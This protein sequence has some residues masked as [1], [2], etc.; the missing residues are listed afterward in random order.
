MRS[1]HRTPILLITA[2]CVLGCTLLAA[3]GRPAL[4]DGQADQELGSFMLDYI[5]RQE[6]GGTANYIETSGQPWVDAPPDA[7][8]IV[9]APPADKIPSDSLDYL[10]TDEPL[11]VWWFAG[12]QLVEVTDKQEAIQKYRQTYMSNSSSNI[13]GWGYYEFGILSLSNGDRDAKVYVG[14]SCGPLCGNGTIYSLHRSDAG[15]W[16][17]T[18]SEM[19]WIS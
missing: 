11:H 5:V 2:A 9:W 16:A 4:P 18:G 12:H 6:I 13:W 10:R 15:K 1:Y 14:V 19:R 3:C 8:I 7:N 17:I